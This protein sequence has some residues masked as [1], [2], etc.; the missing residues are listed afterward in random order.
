M[1]L[2]YFY[3]SSMLQLYC[4]FY[5]NACTFGYKIRGYIFL[6]RKQFLQF[7]SLASNKGISWLVTYKTHL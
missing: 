7:Y 3:A 2:R 5:V 6:L 1:N 4:G